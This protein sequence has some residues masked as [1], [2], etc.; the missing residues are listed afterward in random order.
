M[1]KESELRTVLLKIDFTSRYR[2][3]CDKYN[4]F[5][6]RLRGSH[7]SLYESILEKTGYK[8]NYFS[9]GAFFQITELDQRFEFMLNLVLKDGLVETLLY[10]KEND[11]QILP[12]G[13][14]DFFPEDVDIPFERKK[15]NLPIYES[16]RDLENILTEILSIYEDIK[17]EVLDLQ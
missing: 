11:T 16:E 5:D 1:N 12:G 14:I 3:L 2:Q 13:R 6:S 17:K 15:Y 4:D 10:I 9:K 8:F 7:K